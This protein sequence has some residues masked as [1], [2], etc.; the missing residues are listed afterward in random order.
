MML[1]ITLTLLLLYPK[2]I[3]AQTK[4]DIEFIYTYKLLE[5]MEIPLVSKKKYKIGYI[6]YYSNRWSPTLAAGIAGS[7]T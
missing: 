2:L 4:Q 5:R 6:S 3:D 7:G 1:R